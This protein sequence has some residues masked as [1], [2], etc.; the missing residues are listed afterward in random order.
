[1]VTQNFLNLR[2][3]VDT[4]YAKEMAVATMYFFVQNIR[5]NKLVKL[6]FR[7]RRRRL[8]FHILRKSLTKLRNRMCKL[9]IKIEGVFVFFFLST[10][11]SMNP[12]TFQL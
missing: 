1:M 10:L 9:T 5:I 8:F 6:T 2:I 3:S 12:E 4:I 7:K 11:F